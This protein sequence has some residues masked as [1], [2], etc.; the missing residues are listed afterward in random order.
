M[1]VSNN[2]LYA[3]LC[4]MQYELDEMKKG[5]LDLDVMLRQGEAAAPKRGRGRPKG[6]KNKKP[7]KTKEA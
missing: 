1:R 2:K 5:L 6:S 3:L 4:D 7:R